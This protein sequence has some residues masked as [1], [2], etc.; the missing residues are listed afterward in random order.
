MKPRTLIKIC[1]LTDPVLAREAI[2]LGA[3]YIG[4]MMYKQSKRY[5]KPELAQTIAQEVKKQGGIPVAVFVDAD[6]N[7]MKTLCD[8]CEIDTVQLHG[9]RARQTHHLLPAN[10]QRIYVMS[11]NP[12]GHP[13]ADT[14]QGMI[15]LNPQRDKLLFDGAQGG[16]G[17]RFNLNNFNYSG[18]FFYFL[19][20]GLTPDN[21][22]S[23]IAQ[24]SPPGVDVSSGVE[25]APGVKSKKLIHLFIQAVNR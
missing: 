16:S 5:V 23:A 18:P 17:T 22:S 15:H 14:D 6:A 9:P 13:L 12:D 19:A 2:T 1:G 24:V 11:V 20:G 21:V 3:H 8:Y 10:F 7:E 4:L 25:S